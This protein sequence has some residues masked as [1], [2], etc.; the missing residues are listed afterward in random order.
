MSQ[1]TVLP[2][3]L[4]KGQDFY[5]PSYRVLVQD[6]EFLEVKDVISITYRDSL[7]QIDSFDL[8]LNNWNDKIFGAQVYSD[9]SYKYSDGKR[10]EPWKDIQVWMG[11][12][13]DGKDERR[14]MLTGEIT[15]LAVDFPASGASTL[16]VRGLNLF[17]RFRTEQT[18]EA[19]FNKTDTEIAQ[20]L[21]D[22]IAEEVTKRVPGL[23]LVLDPEDVKR[24]KEKEEKHEYL[25]MDNQYPIF[26]LMQRARRIG[27]ELTMEEIPQE[28]KRQVIFHF[29]STS[30]V[31]KPT[32]ELRWGQNLISFQPTLQTANQVAEVTVRGW[33][34]KKKA[35]IEHTAKRSDLIDEKII[36]PQDLDLAEPSLGQKRE[37]VVDRPIESEA[38]AEKLARAALRKIAEDQITASG[39]TVGV[40]DLRAGS[41]IEVGGL[42]TRFSGTYLVT[43][44]THTL[45]G[46]GYTTDFTAR[47]EA[48]S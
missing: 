20:Q 46:S 27:Y 4:H 6:E 13:R 38:E 47:R 3:S 31:V 37:I 12:Y 42:G 44:T 34:P 33:S 1:P 25:V 35:K 5:V 17:H 23:E 10:F 2:V 7:D 9:Q 43:G 8:K 41:K 26:Y 11:Y 29:R 19:F 15:T 22:S 40:P 39:R 18:T 45:G 14:R 28:E 30:Q 32:Y 48:A 24:N 16:T 36:T 21:I